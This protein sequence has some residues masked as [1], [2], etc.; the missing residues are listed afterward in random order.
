MDLLF[1]HKLRVIK[2]FIHLGNTYERTYNLKHKYDIKLWKLIYLEQLEL[3]QYN[4]FNLEIY[5]P[6]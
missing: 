4:V 2:F 5:L 1:K 3:V 6:I